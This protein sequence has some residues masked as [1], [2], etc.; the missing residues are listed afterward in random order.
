MDWTMME[1]LYLALTRIFD[2]FINFITT[3]FG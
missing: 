3:V 1:Q 2:G